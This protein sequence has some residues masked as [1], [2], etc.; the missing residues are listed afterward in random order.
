MG[1]VGSCT[2]LLY[3]NV[4][5]TEHAEF[6]EKDLKRTALL[7][8]ATEASMP[9]S[10]ISVSSRSTGVSPVFSVAEYTSSDSPDG[11]SEP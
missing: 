5:A 11:A 8:E 9:F 7:Q 10:V 3:K 6:T 4:F 1:K 2:P